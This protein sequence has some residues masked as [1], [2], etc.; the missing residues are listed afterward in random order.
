M[1]GAIEDT[2][3]SSLIL[4]ALESGCCRRQAHR[5]LYT[6]NEY[7]NHER[8]NT[9]IKWSGR[10]CLIPEMFV[11]M[12]LFSKSGSMCFS[13]SGSTDRDWRKAGVPCR[14][15]SIPCNVLISFLFC[16]TIIRYAWNLNKLRKS[17]LW[18]AEHCRYV[19]CDLKTAPR[20]VVISDAWRLNWSA[21]TIQIHGLLK[22][23]FC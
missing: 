20:C 9:A 8:N 11:C 15:V 1:R 12:H 13:W 22:I 19:L 5:L 10:R 23:S 6:D 18:N 4:S 17:F 16:L 14:S 7:F 2:S 21:F 3:A